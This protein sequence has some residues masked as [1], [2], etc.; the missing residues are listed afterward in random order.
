MPKSLSDRQD[1][2]LR[3]ITDE[4]RR[5]GYPPSVREIGEAVGLSSTS[6]VH[7]HLTRLEDKGYIRRDP[8]KPRAIEILSSPAAASG[9]ARDG[10]RLTVDVPLVG[11]IAAGV[12]ILAIENIEETFP[13]PWDLVRGE[14]AFLL[15]VRGDSMVDA[16]IL[17]GDLVLVRQQ[18][19]AHDG[20]I[21][22]ALL[23]DEAT[24]KY[25]YRERDRV[26]LQPA[27]ARLGPIFSRDVRVLGKVIGLIRRFE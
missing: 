1:E 6:T 7:G 19:S 14:N 10:R 8:S 25:F 13:L 27:N 9:L 11:R 21:V 24:V 4:V 3:Y 17:D 16:G 23:G 18:P 20:D 5:R 2:I 12:P 15:E 26:R 22:A